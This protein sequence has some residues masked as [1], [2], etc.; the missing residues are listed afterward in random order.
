LRIQYH[1]LTK[2]KFCIINFA[3]NKV[4]YDQLVK[5]PSPRSQFTVMRALLVFV[6]NHRFQF[7]WHYRSSSR[8][9]YDDA[10]RHTSTSRNADNVIDDPARSLIGVR[11]TCIATL[12]PTANRHSLD[13][14]SPPRPSAKAGSSMAGSVA[15]Y[16]TVG[17]VNMIPKRMR[18]VM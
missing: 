16:R 18:E 7:L 4:G 12:V 17:E 2:T 9:Y 5:P 1:I 15:R 14:L 3:T 6:L 10:S 8:A 13:L 11:L